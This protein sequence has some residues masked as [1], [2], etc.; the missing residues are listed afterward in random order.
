MHPV[1]IESVLKT[2]TLIVDTRE[3]DN[4]RARRRIARI[5]LPYIRRALPCGDYSC[6]VTAPDGST[7][8]FS[9]I[10]SIERKMN[11]DEAIQCFTKHRERF[12]R[13]FL[14]AKDRNMKLYLMIE[15]ASW[16]KILTEQYRSRMNKNALLASLT[17]WLARYD[18]QIIMC[19]E[20]TSSR[21]I[22]EILYREVK[23]RLGDF[24]C[25]THN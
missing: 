1:E 21:L 3:Q 25:Q 12:K 9:E 8:D 15:N 14:R 10:V 19:N 13:E 4:D 7:I 22:K 16:E 18:C 24:E 20:M 6:F 23:E 5:G 2:L 17:A 11:L